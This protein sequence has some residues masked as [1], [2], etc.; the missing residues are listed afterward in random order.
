MAGLT[1][2]T[3][4]G[5]SVELDLRSN[6]MASAGA[7]LAAVAYATLAAATDRALVDALIAGIVVFLGW[8]I[9]RELD[10]DRPQVAAWAMPLAFVASM[11]DLSSALAT[12]VALI[13]IRLVAGTVGAAVTWFDV[14]AL[15][16]AG[17]V[18]GSSSVL[19]IVALTMVIWVFTSPEVGRLK[20]FAL[21]SLVGGIVAGVALSGSSDVAITQNAYILAAIG[22]A[23]MM[24]AMTPSRV[25]ARTD[26]GTEVVDTSRVGLARKTAGGYLMW[27]AVMGGV[28][29]FWMISPVLAALVATAFVRWFSAGA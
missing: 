9:G 18:S 14:L 15:A 25:V 7:I 28:A 13:G 19:W 22:G 11:F 6:R 3:G 23:V 27:A 26:A 21:A 5:R 4:I 1:S 10:P 17:F 8:A 16:L 29:G 12:G 20:W 2:I 24:L